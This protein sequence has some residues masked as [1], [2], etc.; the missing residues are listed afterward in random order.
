MIDTFMNIVDPDEVA[1]NEPWP[2]SSG[3]TLFDIGLKPQCLQQW[4]CPNLKL[5]ES[6]SETRVKRLTGDCA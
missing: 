5:E 3:S 4:V 1:Y 6:T 2:I